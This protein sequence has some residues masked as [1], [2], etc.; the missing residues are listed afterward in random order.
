VNQKQSDGDL[1]DHFKKPPQKAAGIVALR[2]TG[3]EN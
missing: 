1:K 2:L 3:F